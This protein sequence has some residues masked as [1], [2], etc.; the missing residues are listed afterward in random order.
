[1]KSPMLSVALAAAALAP[2]AL[3]DGRQAG[4]VLVYP[5]HRSTLFS[6][7]PLQLQPP[8][9]FFTVISVTNSNISPVNGGTNV[10]FEYVNTIPNPANPNLPLGCFIVDRVEMLTPADT[11][12]VLTNCHNAAGGQEGYLVVSAQNP[13]VFKQ[14][15]SFNHL[16]G[17]ELVVTSLGATY[18]INAIPFSSPL[19]QGQATDLDADGML[20]F[21]DQEYEAIPD[22]LYIQSF[23]A[24]AGSSLT[25]INMT[26]NANAT[27]IVKF[28][29]FNDNEFPLSATL[30]FRCWVEERLDELSLVFNHFFLGNN[31]PNDPSELDLN[32]DNDDDLE[33]GWAIIDGIVATDGQGS[34]VDPALLGA[35]TAGPAIMYGG[36]ADGEKWVS[37]PIDGGVL[38]FESVEKQTNGAFFDFS[39]SALGD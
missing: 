39:G 7:A 31:T 26:G 33:T 20:D 2:A 12:S 28:D 32:C 13:S 19:P 30:S 24:L 3:A 34:E 25:L 36:S 4:S 16:M 6:V 18:S 37:A 23:V 38:L 5:I 29:V 21:D 22:R 14:A 1:M 27:A 8:Q 10:M 11:L 15:W 35:L 9:Q 17:S